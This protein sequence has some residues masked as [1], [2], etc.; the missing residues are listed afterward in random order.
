MKAGSGS[1]LAQVF[2]SRRLAVESASYEALIRLSAFIASF[3]LL[4]VAERLAPRRRRAAECVM[5]ALILGIYA[6]FVWL[7]FIK[8]KWL[9]WNTAWQVTVV[10]P[11]EN[12]DPEAGE[13][14]AI[15]VPS[16]ASEVDGLT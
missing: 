5:D 7:I 16:T 15:P 8:F 9:P 11:R 14:I 13:Q 4:V 2:T 12:V 6:F 1:E 3:T 10:S